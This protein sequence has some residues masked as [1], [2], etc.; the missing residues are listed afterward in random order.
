MV[1]NGNTNVYVALFDILGFSEL[2]KNNELNRVADSYSR[3]KEVFEDIRGHVNAMNKGFKMM[4]VTVECRSFS[5]TFLIYTSKTG[6]RAFL[7][8]LTAC[9]GLFIGAIENGLLLRGSITRG[10]I[11]AQTGVEI[12]KPIV[13]AYKNEQRQEWSGCWISNDCLE[14]IDLTKFLSD[15]SLVEYEIP[16]KDGKVERCI[17]F[18]WVKSLVWKAMHE[19]GKNNFDLKQIEDLVCF[20]NNEETDWPVRRKQNNTRKFLDYVLSPDFMAAYKKRTDN[21]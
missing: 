6:D 1:V 16:L 12:G 20:M 14:D 8:L 21:E 17:A 11:I 7:S 4:D 3:A 13:D 10:A 2:V 5:D 15:K 9:D 19:K 18:N